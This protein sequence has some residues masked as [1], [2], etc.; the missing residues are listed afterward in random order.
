[1]K[2]R[3]GGDH[4]SLAAHYQFDLVKLLDKALSTAKLSQEQRQEVCENFVFDLAM[5]HDQGEVTTGKK[6]ARPVL[7]FRDGDALLVAAADFDLHEY[8]FG[9]VGQYFDEIDSD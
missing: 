8:A 2:I 5:L 3:E 9:N 1:M 4:E 6:T 7:A